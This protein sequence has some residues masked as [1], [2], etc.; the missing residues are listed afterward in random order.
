GV[1]QLWDPDEGTQ[2]ATLTGHTGDVFTLAF[3]PDGERL[4][5]G[6]GEV[7]IWDVASEQEILTLAVSARQARFVEGGE[8]IVV[9]GNKALSKL[10]GEGAPRLHTWDG[11]HV[12]E[13]LML[14]GAG[15]TACL[16]PDGKHLV[17]G[18]TREAILLGDATTGRKLGTWKGHTE[19]VRRLAFSAD[20][21]RVA[22]AAEDNTV[23]IWNMPAGKDPL[24]CSGHRDWVVH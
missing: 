20:S 12:R 22:S 7:K 11:R 24:T 8:H 2:L 17:T 1:V 6:G 19:T 18:G 13:R 4:L 5:S 9:A 23:R 16:S 10:V 3:S 15:Q 21:A 14:Q